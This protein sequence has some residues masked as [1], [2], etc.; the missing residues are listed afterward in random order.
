MFTP[1]SLVWPSDGIAI[2]TEHHGRPETRAVPE[3]A[4]NGEI[5]IAARATPA[6]FAAVNAGR[7]FMSVEFNALEETRTAGGVREIQRAM[8]SAAALTDSP[9][10]QQARA[11]L[12]DRDEVRV[13]L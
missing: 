5:R 10:Y 12:R 4:P 9:E 6:V 7:R 1:G 8:V 13:W 2:L 3:R 11:E